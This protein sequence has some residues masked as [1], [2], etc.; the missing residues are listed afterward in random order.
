MKDNV[1]RMNGALKLNLDLTKLS[2]PELQDLA[3]KYGVIGVCY[4]SREQLIAKITE[5][6]ANPDKEIEVSGILEKMPDGY[7]F[8]RLLEADY[9]SSY[10]DIYVSHNLIRKYNLRTG[11]TIAGAIKRP[12]EGEKYFALA[13]INEV[14][15]QNPQAMFERPLFEYLDPMHPKSKL[16]LDD[17]PYISVRLIDIFAPIGKGQRGLIVAPPKA[18]KTILLKELADTIGKNHPEAFVIFLLIDERPEEVADMQHSIKHKNVE[19]VSSTFDESAERH[20]L[21]AEAVLAKAKRLVECGNDVVIILDSITRLARAYNT[22]APSS[23]KVLT[24]GVDAFALQAP[25]KFFGAARNIEGVGSLTILASALIETGSKMDEVIFE[26]FKGTGNMELVL[27]R[28]LAT[29]RLFPAIDIMQSGTRRE[30]LLISE[31]DLAK[32]YILRKFIAS[33]N[34]IFEAMEIILDNI[35]STKNNNEFFEKM[36]GKSKYL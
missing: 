13:K 10:D 2:I 15:F 25:K 3:H 31:N 36:A 4:L 16:R 33:I 27:S 1:N 21:V 5:L 8:L 32:I 29:L 14:N 34:N 23:G 6:E 18:G 24:G 35:K 20:I 17:S 26:E 28:R 7:G 30:E 12:R 9:I 19:I 22:V 11:D